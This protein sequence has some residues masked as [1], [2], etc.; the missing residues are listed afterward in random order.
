MTAPYT[1]VGST[2]GLFPGTW[3]LTEV[4]SMYRRK[5]DRVPLI[6][7]PNGNLQGT[8]NNLKKG[9]EFTGDK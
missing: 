8:G 2:D 1:P 4:D 9:W 6:Q 7:I 3:F 5:Y